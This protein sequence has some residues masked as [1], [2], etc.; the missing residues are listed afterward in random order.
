MNKLVIVATSTIVITVLFLFLFIGHFIFA[1]FLLS[2]VKLFIANI[3][4]YAF[5]NKFIAVTRVR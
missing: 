5:A 2:A 3:E 1:F 4:L